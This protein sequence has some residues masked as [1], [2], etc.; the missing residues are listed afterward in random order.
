MSLHGAQ[1]ILDRE[2]PVFVGA[3]ERPR[4]KMPALASIARHWQDL[5]LDELRAMFPALRCFYIGWGEPFC[6]RCG[7]LAPTKDSSSYP[8]N[9]KGQRCV[10]FAWNDAK[11]WLERAHLQDHSFGGTVEGGNLVPLCALCHEN[12][13]ICKTQEDGIAY[14]N[15]GSEV[16]PAMLSLVQRIT[17][18]EYQHKPA[19]G[20]ALRSIL[21]AHAA[22]GAVIAKHTLGDG[23]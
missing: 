20:N 4:E 18:A 13:P 8:A 2:E 19:K 23:A 7:W 9:W 3:E 1:R 6:F 12:Q 11:G 10:D 16:P 5:S 17:D 21:R 14:V 15:A 22:A